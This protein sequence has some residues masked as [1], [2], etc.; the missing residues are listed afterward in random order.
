MAQYFASPRPLI[1]LKVVPRLSVTVLPSATIASQAE[2]IA[3][4]NN[5]KAMTALRTAD[6]IKGYEYA[7]NGSTTRNTVERFSDYICVRDFGAVGDGTTD[8]TAAFNAALA[9]GSKNVIY[10]VAGDIYVVKDLVLNGKQFDGRGCGL[11][12]A[13]GAKWGVKLQGYNPSIKNCFIQDQ[14][15]YVSNTTLSAT[16]SSG[17][18]SLSVTSAAGIEIGD[19]VLLKTDTGDQRFL[20]YVTAVS[21]TTITI[22][23]AIPSTAT[24]AN[25]VTFMTAFLVVGTALWW[26]ISDILSINCGGGVLIKPANDTQISNKGT[27][28]SFYTDGCKYFGVIKAENAA[29][30]KADDLKLWGG[31]VE[32]TNATGN[33]TAGPFSFPTKIFLLRDVTVTVGGVAKTYGTHWNFASQSSIQFTVGNYPASGAAIVISHFRDAYRGFVDDQRNTSIISGG[34]CYSKV[35]VLDFYVGVQ[36]ESVELTDFSD[37]IADSCQYSALTM[38]NCVLTLGF[39][40]KTF[41]GFSGNSIIAYSTNGVSFTNLYTSRVPLAY[42]Y[43]GALDNNIYSSNSVLL[44]NAGNWNG[45]DYQVATASG[46]KVDIFGGIVMQFSSDSAIAASTTT[47]LTTKSP[48]SITGR[49]PYLIPQSGQLLKLHV[50]SSSAPGA[51][52]S[53]TFTPNINGTDYPSAAAAITGAGVYSAT[54]IF[55]QGFNAE[56]EI[57]LKLVTDAATPSS[58]FR[59]YLTAK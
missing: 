12:D 45:G 33:G 13:S 1:R 7:V 24:S 5:T 18:T 44:I 17:S 56:S 35:E 25:P 28:R 3:G 22:R 59:A 4:T 51:G 36:A 46:G 27:F 39:Q 32:T 26:N 48:S 55:V 29:G 2:A 42:Q 10:G 8:D 14:S 58:E 37:L 54:S 57:V 19:V 40:G 30:I 23:D 9:L 6:A 47:Y 50:R 16:A 20:T 49:S 21:G 38:N 53:Y 15:N 34:N 43:L 52:K 41:L 31:Y 11:R